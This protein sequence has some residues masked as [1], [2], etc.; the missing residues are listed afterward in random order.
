MN[1]EDGGDDGSTVAEEEEDIYA[2]YEPTARHMSIK[3]IY[4]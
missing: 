2:K 1:A 3:L 4:H